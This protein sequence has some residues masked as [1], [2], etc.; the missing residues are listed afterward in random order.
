MEQLFFN[1]GAT[2]MCGFMAYIWKRSD[3]TNVFIKIAFFGLTLLG[4]FINLKNFGY[5]IKI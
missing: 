2:V 1:I 3:V 4:I 5:V